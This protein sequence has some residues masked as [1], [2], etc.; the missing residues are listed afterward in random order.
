M[1]SSPGPDAQ[2]VEHEDERVGA[3]RDA[4]RLARRRGRPAASCSNASTFG[5]RMKRPESSTSSS[6]PSTRRGAARTAPSRRR[7]GSTKRQSTRQPAGLPRLFGR[8]A[9]PPA[10]G[11]TIRYTIAEHDQR[12]DH[13]VDLAEVVVER[14]PA[15]AERVAGAGEAEA[16][17]Q[18][19]E[20]RQDRVAARAAPRRSRPGSRRR[21]ARPAASGATKHGPVVVALEPALRALELLGRHVEPASMPLEQRPAAVAADPQPR[22]E[23]SR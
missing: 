1:T 3:V 12:D 22:I 5:P 9:A 17:G 18:R 6:R 2:R 14:L 21:S 13:V 8:R 20:E 16:P 7:A 11:R 23:P 15:R 4:D 19:A 10:P